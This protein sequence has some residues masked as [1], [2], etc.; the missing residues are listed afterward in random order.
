M[1]HVSAQLALGSFQQRKN[2]FGSVCCGFFLL[3]ST[4]CPSVE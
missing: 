4:V 3:F 2:E 1:P